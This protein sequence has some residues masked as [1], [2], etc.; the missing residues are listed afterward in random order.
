MGNYS[1]SRELARST[2][3][4]KLMVNQMSFTRQSGRGS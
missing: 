3:A 4:R 2:G 1:V